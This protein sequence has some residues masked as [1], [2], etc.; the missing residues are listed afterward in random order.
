M[1]K[2][3]E[4]KEIQ[5]IALDI[6][7]FVQSVCDSNGIVY[8][9][10]FGTALGA[11]RHRGFIPWDDDLD[12]YMPRN[13]FEKFCTIMKGCSND[14]FELL[15][16]DQNKR[17][18]LP[19]PKVVDKRTEL[20]QINHYKPMHLGVYIDIFPL[21]VVPNDKK[22]STKLITKLN[23]LQRIWDLVDYIPRHRKKVFQIIHKPIVFLAHLFR[24]SHFLS[25]KMNRIA[26]R[27]CNDG[28]S[29]LVSSLVYSVYGRNKETM[30]N[31]VFSDGYL[32]KFENISCKVP[33]QYDVYLKQIYG[34]YMELPPEEKRVTEHTFVAWWREE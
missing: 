11:I 18:D 12:I 20:V 2:Y 6:L 4:S 25:K 26:K 1:K 34:N 13:D 19:L 17:Y 7:K 5:T 15:F 22:K 14:R 29:S 30:S 21:D 8:Y 32:C 9:L 10:A 16:A 3:I 31:N 33:K 23:K 28:Q 27:Y 24:M